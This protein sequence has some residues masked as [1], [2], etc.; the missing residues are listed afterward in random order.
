[1]TEQEAHEQFLK[2]VTECFSDCMD[3]ATRVYIANLRPHMTDQQQADVDGWLEGEKDRLVR[4]VGEFA[5][6]LPVRRQGES[7]DERATRHSQMRRGFFKWARGFIQ[8]P[9]A[10]GRPRKLTA[11]Q[12]AK[13]VERV[14]GFLA[15]G[16]TKQDAFKAAGEPFD[17]SAST[18]RRLWVDYV[19]S[20][21]A[22]QPLGLRT[23]KAKRIK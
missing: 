13:I 8:K 5:H 6:G 14:S 11:S 1:M 19:K 23:A 18:V 2:A 21:R 12:A 17:A 10:G 16:S 7:R 22:T 15:E 4:S 20:R 9:A 3:R